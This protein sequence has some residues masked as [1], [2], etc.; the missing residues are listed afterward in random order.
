[1]LS[2]NGL[3][4]L[5]HIPLIHFPIVSVANSTRLGQEVNN[6]WNGKM[7][8]KMLDISGNVRWAYTIACRCL[9]LAGTFRNRWVY[10]SESLYI[11]TTR[12][13]PLTDQIFAQSDSCLGHQVA[14]TENTKKCWTNGWINSKFL[15]YIHLIRIHDIIAGF[16][17]WPTFQ[18]H[19]GQSSSGSFS[20]ACFVAT[21]AIGL[22]L[23][24][25]VTLGQLTSWTK[26]RSNLIIGLAT[27][28]AKTENTKCYYSWSTCNS[29][30]CL[31]LVHL[32]LKDT[33]HNTWIFDLTYFWRSQYS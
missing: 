24:T 26:F 21:G 29:S 1:V 22:K 10:W 7:A 28:G 11:C 16:L 17:I 8:S 6:W 23:R 19:R 13:T 18:G 12:S 2:A 31:S 25:Y 20:R 14:K 5:F 30:K 27:R 4:C 32:I 33:W 3:Q 15:S 9:P